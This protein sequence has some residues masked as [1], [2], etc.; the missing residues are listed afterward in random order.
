MKLFLLPAL[1]VLF[2]SVCSLAAD[3]LRDQVEKSLRTNVLEIWFP[4]IIDKE[5]GGFLCDFNADW[6]PAGQQLKTNVYR[7]RAI[8]TASQA[9][10]RYPSDPWRQHPSPLPSN[11]YSLPTR[12]VS[13]FIIHRS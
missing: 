7:A 10:R 8:W 6:K 5:N 4:R 13:S 2:C 11:L 12:S 1:L 9:A 3:P